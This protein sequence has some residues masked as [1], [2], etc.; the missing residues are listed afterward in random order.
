MNDIRMRRSVHSAYESGQN[1]ILGA[2]NEIVENLKSEILTELKKEIRSNF[3]VILNS[4]SLTPTS[5]RPVPAVAS[6]RSR[7]LF[8]KP[9]AVNRS[10]QSLACGTADS[11]S[12]S[13]SKFA[14]VAPKQKFWLYLSRIACAVTTDDVRALVS[15]RLGT[16]DAEVVRLVANGR[17]INTMSFISFKVGLNID[18]KEKALS[19]TTWPRGIYFR[20][21]EDNRASANFWNPARPTNPREPFNEASLNPQSGSVTLME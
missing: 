12:P 17:D 16:D 4:N 18:I 10:K 14:A 9:T 1:N 2:H 5:R 11:L 15:Q 21:F 3:A 6:T 7:R 8:D 13:F 19:P 20:E